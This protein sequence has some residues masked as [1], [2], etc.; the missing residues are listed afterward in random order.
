LHGPISHLAEN[1]PQPSEQG[2]RQCVK[3]ID[4]SGGVQFKLITTKMGAESPMKVHRERER[5]RERERRSDRHTDAES[6]Y[7]NKRRGLSV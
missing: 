3:L 7:G 4:E 2:V 6:A 5:E 1:I